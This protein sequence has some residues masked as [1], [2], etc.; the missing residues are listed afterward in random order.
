MIEQ[1]EVWKVQTGERFDTLKEAQEY[2]T[3]QLREV[4]SK[5][6]KP[7]LGPGMT[8]S[9]QYKVIMAILPDYEAVMDLN[10]AIERY[11]GP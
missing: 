1:I 8:A 6:L 10:R 5:R 9:E 3:D 4:L 7:L 11:L 2:V